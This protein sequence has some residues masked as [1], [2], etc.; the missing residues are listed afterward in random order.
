MGT[1][2]VLRAL[3]VFGVL[4]QAST[5]DAQTFPTGK[6]PRNGLRA[7]KG[8]EAQ[9]AA[10]GMKLLSLT[11]KAGVFDTAKIGDLSFANSDLAFKGNYI[12]QGN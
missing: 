12:Y 4:S 1:I 6:D 10:H 9:E 8:A 5:L 2:R 11:P 7:G 3:A